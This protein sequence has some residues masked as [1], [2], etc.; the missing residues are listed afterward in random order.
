VSAARR[1]V[2]LLVDDEA[3]VLSALRRS[4]RREGYEI[5]SAE[6]AAE[7]LRILEAREVD[8]VLTDQKMPRMGGLEL[9]ERAARLRPRAA[10]LLIT[11][12]M[13]E[14]PRARLEALGVRALIPK[15]W[16]DA[17]LKAE[18]RKALG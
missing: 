12:W 2:L 5:V 7:A 6:T 17:T 10:R 13:G 18:L 4:L 9:L 1:P 15:P 11:G 16:D 3:H 14:V 8:A